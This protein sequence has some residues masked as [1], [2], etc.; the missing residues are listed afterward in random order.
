MKFKVVSFIEKQKW[1]YPSDLF[2]C[3]NCLKTVL[4]FL[5]L[6]SVLPTALAYLSHFQKMENAYH[7]ISLVSK[8][9]NDESISK[10]NIHNGFLENFKPPLALNCVDAALWAG[11]QAAD[12]GTKQS[13][14]TQYKEIM[15]LKD[16]II[17]DKA[18]GN[19]LCSSDLKK[20]SD[21]DVP[22]PGDYIFLLGRSASDISKS[23]N[24]LGKR[25]LHAGVFAPGDHLLNLNPVGVATKPIQYYVRGYEQAGNKVKGVYFCSPFFINPDRGKDL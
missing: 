18:L 13:V 21:Q 9:T 25:I 24:L 19:L 6:F 4:F 16:E 8:W 10:L 5:V 15:S 17:R 11:V 3:L 20:I 1:D 2:S 12:E 7:E 23:K 14:V 22:N